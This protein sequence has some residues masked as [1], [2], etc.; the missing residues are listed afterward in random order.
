MA[1]LLKWRY[2][3]L[4]WDRKDQLAVER[5]PIGVGCQAKT[6]WLHVHACRF[7]VYARRRVPPTQSLQTRF[8]QIG[9]NHPQL[10]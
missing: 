10:A 6:T 7:V 5:A 3:C 2:N 1:T 9:C 4:S 8:P